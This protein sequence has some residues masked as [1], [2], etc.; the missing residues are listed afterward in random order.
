[1]RTQ[2][3][4]V[5]G[6]RQ[7]IDIPKEIFKGGVIDFEKVKEGLVPSLEIS[8][9]GRKSIGDV[10]SI[11]SFEKGMDLEIIMIGTIPIPINCCTTSL[12]LLDSY[13]FK[14]MTKSLVEVEEEYI[15]EK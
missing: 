6:K 14:E 2:K 15:K 12:T 3:Q 13:K 11:G 10:E 8:K 9:F 5:A 4:R 1:M 7:S